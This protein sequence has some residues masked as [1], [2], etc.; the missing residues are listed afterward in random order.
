MSGLASHEQAVID[1][2]VRLMSI[3]RQSPL[4]LARDFRR[5]VSRI[6][7]E[8]YG[9]AGRLALLHA[10]LGSPGGSGRLP[11][12][13]ML[14]LMKVLAEEN[15]LPDMSTPAVAALVCSATHAPHFKACD[16]GWLLDHGVSP[17]AG[18]EGAM[19]L[20][21]L[22][23]FL[24]RAA[25]FAEI[26]RRSPDPSAPAFDGSSLLSRCLMKVDAVE[27]GTWKLLHQAG[28]SFH[29]PDPDGKTPAE[30]FQGL[31]GFPGMLQKPA[32]AELA[33]AIAAE[34]LDRSTPSTHSKPRQAR[35]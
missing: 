6:S 24:G 1:D 29:A 35:L 22:C 31:A 20:R 10:A 26:W 25:L 9:Q 33:A 19:S 23:A 4:D 7:P 14:P 28:A 32:M 17:D 12:W 3:K 2:L 34:H 21:Y 5:T 30:I 18:A 11:S 16:L 15:L 8:D 27:A 13:E